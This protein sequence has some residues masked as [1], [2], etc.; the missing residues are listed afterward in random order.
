MCGHVCNA[1]YF[2]ILTAH[3]IGVFYGSGVLVCHQHPLP[4][5]TILAG[6]RHE[7]RIIYEHK[8]HVRKVEDP[9]TLVFNSSVTAWKNV[10]K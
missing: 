9:L 6:P 2:F 5:L 4:S 10:K 8:N 1:C 3:I 7:R